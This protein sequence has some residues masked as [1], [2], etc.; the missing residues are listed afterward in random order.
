MKRILVACG[1]G[2][3]T[4][5]AVKQ[6]LSELLT[7]RGYGPE[8]VAF[9]QCRISDLVIL[10]DSYDLVVTTVAL[11]PTIKTPYILG[12]AFLTGLGVD[13]VLDEIIQ[14]LSK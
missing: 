4:S 3:A 10:P 13:K 2:V 5:A 12:L 6:K 1:A 8:K 7:Q 14:T 11:P 9:G